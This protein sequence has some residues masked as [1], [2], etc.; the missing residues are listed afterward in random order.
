MAND[1]YTV[2]GVSRSA[3][4]DEVRAAYKR[5]A[6]ANHP[7]LNAGDEV[8]AERFKAASAA[9]EII[10]DADK[11]AQYD[12]GEIDAEGQPRGASHGAW[13]GAG[14]GQSDG[15]EDLLS[16]LFGGGRRRP[17]PQR[18][19][20][21][22]YRVEIAF[23]D[24]VTGAQRDMTMADGRRLTVSIPAGIETGQ[25]L[26]LR[27]QGRPAKGK[28]PPG[29]ALLE[30]EV[31]QSSVWTRKGD[32]LHMSVPVAL[33]TAILGGSV[34]ANTP[35]GPVTFKVPTG[36]NSGQTLR[37]RGKGV[38]RAAKPGHL[39]VRLDIMVEDAEDPQL[40]AWAKAA[41]ERAAK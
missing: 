17:G 37:L 41:Q 15:F 13:P 39:Y 7:D 33:H 3:S 11:R 18:G 22:R 30:I 29:D 4:A 38:Q 27:S 9:Y 2:L 23:E 10:G 28:G 14:M 24:A 21:I 1:P 36:S 8:K 20:D 19:A 26:R 12:R 31:R 6:K 35:A 16:G 5:L 40:R 25:T 34:D 32:D